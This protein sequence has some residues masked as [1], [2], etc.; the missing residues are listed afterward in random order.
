M[1]YLSVKVTFLPKILILCKKKKKENTD[2]SKIQGSLVLKG[3]FSGTAYVCLLTHQIS[4]FY[5]NPNDF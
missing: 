5:H 1:L 3:V 2:I 4:N